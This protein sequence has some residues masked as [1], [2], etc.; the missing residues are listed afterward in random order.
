MVDYPLINVLLT[1]RSNRSNSEQE[2][3]MATKIPSEFRDLFEKNAF[4]HL[5]TVMNDGSP[6]VT[7]VWRD[8]DGTQVEINSAKGR[9]QDK[10]MTGNRAVGLSIQDAENTDRFVAV[11]GKVV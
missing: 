8:Y 11:R 1:Y 6:Q 7:P 5:A 4:A 2:T 9:I 3:C 10:H